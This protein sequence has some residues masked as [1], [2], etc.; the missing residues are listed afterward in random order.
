MLSIDETKAKLRAV[1]AE[2]GYGN[3]RTAF[4]ELDRERIPDGRPKRIKASPSEK[5]HMFNTQQG[6][7]PWKNPDKENPHRLLIPARYNEC[8]EINPQLTEG[9]NAKSNKQ[10]LCPDCNRQKSAMSL[11]EQAKHQ[12]ET[13]ETI[14]SRRKLK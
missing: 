9:Y 3:F 7:C 2:S 10:L 5:Q 13:M 4:K 6:M 12:G 14:L 8:D 11:Q 1:R